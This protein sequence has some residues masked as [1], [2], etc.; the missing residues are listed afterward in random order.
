MFLDIN[1]S[2]KAEEILRESEARYR[3]LANSLPDIV[4][5]TDINGQLVFANERA[6]EISGYSQGD[7]EKGLNIMQFLL[8]ED[9]EKATK[10]I[11]RLLSGGNYVPAEYTFVRKN[12]TTF[13]ALITATPC[14]SKNKV[15]GLRGLVLDITERKRTEERLEKEQQ[16]LNR[17][18]DSSPI[19]IFYKDNEGKFIRVNEAFAKAQRIPKD[20]FFGKTVFDFYS[21]EIAR[22]MANDDLAVLKSGRPKL[23]IISDGRVDWAMAELLA[24][25]TLVYDGHPVA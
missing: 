21:A 13:P 24:Y 8:P 19:I 5:E 2:K 16:E 15:T 18:I 14:I 10:T 9:R 3:E 6:A 1:E 11:Q 23:G 22:G 4:F 12:G 25:G 17:I 20:E 7:L